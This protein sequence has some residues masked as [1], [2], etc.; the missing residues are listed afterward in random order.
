[1]KTFIL[2]TAAA[3]TLALSASAARAEHHHH[4]YHGQN[5]VALGYSSNW[6]VRPTTAYG[7]GN[8]YGYGSNSG[9]GQFH[10]GVTPLNSGWSVGSFNT[11]WSGNYG[12]YN[13]GSLN[14]YGYP[15]P[16]VSG[17]GNS[18]LTGVYNSPQSILPGGCYS[19]GQNFTY[20]QGS[21]YRV[22]QGYGLTGYGVR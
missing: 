18:G 20:P 16:N 6:G 12:G 8:T 13:N 22:H 11:G 21:R 9:Y 5:S 19:N 17:Y 2:T 10:P 14:G 4:D 1:M 15:R 7:Y 3:V